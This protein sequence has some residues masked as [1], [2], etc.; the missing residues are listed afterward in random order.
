M[1][2]RIVVR[3]G[4]PLR[5]TVTVEGAK[6][7]VL[8]ILAASLLPGGPSR[9]HRVPAVDDVF[10]V[11]EVLRA[12]GARV[13]WEG[14]SLTVDAADVLADAAPDDLVRRMRAAFWV[15]GPLLARNGRARI[16][17]PG[18]CAIGSRPIDL[19]LKGLAALGAEISCDHGRV[20]ARASHLRGTRIY[21]DVPSV[22][23]TEHLLMTAALADGV[24]LIENAAEEPEVVDLA[25][26]LVSRGARIAGAGT[27][28]IRVEGVRELTAGEHTVIPDRIE[29]G[30]F[31]LA[32]AITGGEVEV[33]EMIP[34][35]CKPVTAKLREAG[36][37][38]AEADGAVVVRAAARPRAV[39][40]KT[41][42]YPGFPT[43]MQAPFMAVMAVAE[44]NSLIIET[45]FE[46]RFLHVNELKRMGADITIEGRSALVRGKAR[47]SGAS[48]Q[49]TDIRGAAALVLAAL[50]AEGSS[51]IG[52]VH[53]L[54]RGYARMEAKLRG[55]G[56]DARRR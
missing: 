20:Q 13:R 10:T 31:M 50:A 22:G 52:A 8:P 23:A 18:G 41:L 48:V 38:V 56:A 53:H 51:E 37:E 15:L 40:V 14:N 5:G 33:A 45:V 4:T 46:N 26:Y 2:E 24:T 27:R 44:G 47:L 42:P 9:I 3:G 7:S 12:L 32:A 11:V 19:H 1:S 55:L 34:E 29:A 35:H 17:L 54:D 6:N 36:V 16:A 39:D 49:A 28:R 43:D 25:G 30:T 21:L